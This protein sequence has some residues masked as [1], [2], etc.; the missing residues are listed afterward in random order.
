M[1]EC[2]GDKR[3]ENVRVAELNR[4]DIVQFQCANKKFS[5][6]KQRLSIKCMQKKKD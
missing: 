4:N 6:F 5:A 3:M 2:K 1:A